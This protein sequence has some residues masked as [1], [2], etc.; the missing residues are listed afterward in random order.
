MAQTDY[1]Q[2]IDTK[3]FLQNQTTYDDAQ[4]L[5]LAADAVLFQEFDITPD[6]AFEAAEDDFTGY[7]GKGGTS[8]DPMKVDWRG[9]KNILPSGSAGTAPDDF[10]LWSTGLWAAGSSPAATTVSGAGSTVVVVDVADASGI[11]VGEIVG[12]DLTSGS[13]TTVYARL[14]TAVDTGATPDNITITPPLPSAPA[15]S[16]AVRTSVTYGQAS[17]CE[18]LCFTAW[19]HRTHGAKLGW[20]GVVTSYSIGVGDRHPKLEVSGFMRGIGQAADTTISEG[21][22]WL[23]GATTLTVANP[24][25]ISVG[26]TLF[27]ESE[28]F[29][30]TGKASTGVLTVTRGTVGAAAEHADTTAVSV[31]TPTRTLAGNPIPK[32]KCTLSVGT[33]ATTVQV[34]ESDTFDVNIDASGS[35]IPHERQTGDY[36]MRHG[37]SFSDGTSV[38]Y[39][40]P[41][42]KQK[43]DWDWWGRAG[44]DREACGTAADQL[45]VCAQYGNCAGKIMA[46]ISPRCVPR[47]SD[48]GSSGDG[49]VPATINLDARDSR[50]ATTR[51]V[52]VAFL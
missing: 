36:W 27:C 20:G 38:T 52:Y 12:V 40:A 14:V 49:A 39:S 43:S 7:T 33:A 6:P 5:A 3:V 13:Y 17:E 48:D 32:A 25:R 18:E 22:A 44:A 19:A 1:E 10:L 47:I 34:M 35:L 16:A 26:M 41:V 11:S 23:I 30:V 9:I 37:Y 24:D 4:T 50:T 15:A 28:G 29:L 42:L 45:P 2:F 8:T 31:Y 21:G 46:V 51:M